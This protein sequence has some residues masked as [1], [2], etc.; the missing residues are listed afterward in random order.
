MTNKEPVIIRYNPGWAGSMEQ[1]TEFLSNFPDV[2]Q[3][4]PGKACVA[5]PVSSLLGQGQDL[6]IPPTTIFLVH[7]LDEDGNPTYT[8]DGHPHLISLGLAEELNKAE[9]GTSAWI[10][11]GADEL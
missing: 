6:T 7:I 10:I 8:E 2:Y 9:I 1:L 3:R 5:G 11:T 4:T